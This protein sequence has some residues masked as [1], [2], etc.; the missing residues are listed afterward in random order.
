MDV[1][2][3]DPAPASNRRWSD[4]PIDW[5]RGYQRRDLSVFPVRTDGTKAP[6][7]KGW[8][9]FAT[10]RPTD[11]ELVRWFDRPAPCAVGIACGEASGNLVVLDFEAGNP[12]PFDGWLARLGSDDLAHLQR[13][14]LVRTPSTGVHVYVRLPLAVKGSV[15]A[16]DPTGRKVRVETRGSQHAVIAPGSPPQ[17]HSTGRPYLL[18]RAGWLDGGPAEPV[19]VEVFFDWTCHAADLNEYVRPRVVVGDRPR[20]A[21]PAGGRPGDHFNARV[22]WEA[23]LSRHDWRPC[24]RSGGAVYWT[25]PGKAEGVS[26]STGFCQGE[27]AGDLLYVFST[28]AAPFEAGKAYSRFAAYALLDHRGDFA[29]AARALSLAG[30]GRQLPVRKGAYR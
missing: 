7:L 2:V 4:R 16:R 22:G 29:T 6:A 27:T 14:P 13:C 15:L 17:T 24:R 19:P 18:E 10:R 3:H 23:V 20:D 21:A 25:R 5:A 8:R 12:A 28:S 11:A 1:M 26:A 30:Y 9:E